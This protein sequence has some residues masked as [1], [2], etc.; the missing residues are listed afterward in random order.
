MKAI[1]GGLLLVSTL[2][3]QYVLFCKIIITLCILLLTN[4]QRVT[5]PLV[6]NL[7][8]LIP[9]IRKSEYILSKY[10]II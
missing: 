7:I 9:Y 6:G 4:I 5:M 2:N 8:P 1:F 3:K 10:V